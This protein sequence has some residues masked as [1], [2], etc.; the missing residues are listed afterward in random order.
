MENEE[1]KPKS[2]DD[3]LEQLDNSIKNARNPIAYKLEINEKINASAN[4]GGKPPT[5]KEEDKD[6]SQS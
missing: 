5:K 6:E 4:A 2:S 3:M 1:V